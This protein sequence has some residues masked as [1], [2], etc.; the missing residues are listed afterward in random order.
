MF[1]HF[2]KKSLKF[3]TKTGLPFFTQRIA[4]IA[5]TII[6]NNKTQGIFIKWNSDKVS[7]VKTTFA[8]AE[9]NIIE[10]CS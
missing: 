2:L 10:K 7:K 3:G 4:E 8:N 5:H 1:L 6:F 9:I